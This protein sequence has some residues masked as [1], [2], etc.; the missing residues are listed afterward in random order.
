LPWLAV[1][2]V[3]TGLTLIPRETLIKFSHSQGA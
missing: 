1:Q 3:V 2:T